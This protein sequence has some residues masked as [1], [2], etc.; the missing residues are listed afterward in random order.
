[1]PELV[2]L[3]ALLSVGTVLAG[4]GAIALLGLQLLAWM[5]F[6]PIR[7]FGWLLMLPLLLL[8]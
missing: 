8:K 1:M 2:S 7:I 5:L 6:L 3:F 4:I